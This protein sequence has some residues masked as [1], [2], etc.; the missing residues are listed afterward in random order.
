MFK[1]VS[2]PTLLVTWI[3]A[4]A[5]CLLAAI[6]SARAQEGPRG[7]IA[8]GTQPLLRDSMPPG[9]VGAIQ[10]LRKPELRG[11]WQ[12]VE[13]KGPEG[14]RLS[15][16]DAGQFTDDLAESRIAVMVGYVY[17][18]RLTGLPYQEDSALYPTL[19]IIDR[20][21][22]PPE[23]EHRFP[24]PIEIDEDDINEALRGGMVMRV[25]YLEDNE[26][27]EPVET[28]GRPQRV[29]DLRP[30]QDALRTADQLGRP[31][32]ILRIGS[33]VPNV[34]EGQDWDNFLFGCPAWTALKPIPTKQMLIDRGN[35]PATA[36]SG[37][38]S[39][40]R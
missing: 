13:L 29:L 17:R 22:P 28:A 8:P 34:S 21:H 24:I 7:R 32:A 27:A 11:V 26:I 18:M 9:E 10:L 12:A 40:R 38:I 1:R 14:M 3:A 23:R 19:E 20:I 31:V 35:L 33:R 5:M 4:I 6:A 16:A 2:F 30:T 39:D 15:M 37:S 25:V 36:N